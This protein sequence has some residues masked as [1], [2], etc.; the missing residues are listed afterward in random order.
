M[1][2]SS[3]SSVPLTGFENF[4]RHWDPVHNSQ[5]V[6][7]LP[8]EFY[9]TRQPEGLITT[10]GSCVSACIRDASLGLGGM[11]HFMLPLNSR[12]RNAE[13]DSH[14]WS[15]AARYG[16]YA[17]ELLINAIVRN[18]GARKNLEVKIFGGA[19][20][21]AHMRQDIGRLNIDFIREY[22][23]IEELQVLAEDLGGCY[24]RKVLYFPA[25]GK[26]RVKRLEPLVSATIARREAHYRSGLKR[27]DISGGVELFDEPVMD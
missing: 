10:L 14:P 13:E 22:L 23:K 6:K 4:R 9:V 17:M 24:P 21:I 16:D 11:N 27:R 20:I 19:K 12:D 8:G 2:R 26:A 1:M 5:T 18:G 7:I 3:A 25:T 15:V